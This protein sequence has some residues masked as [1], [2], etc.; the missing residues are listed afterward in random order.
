MKYKISDYKF[1]IKG[2][3]ITLSILIIISYFFSK[4]YFNES[5]EDD[6]SNLSDTIT[7][8]NSLL[9]NMKKKIKNQKDK[10]EYEIEEFD[11][12]SDSESEESDS[13]DESN[14][15]IEGLKSKK[16]AQRQEKKKVKQ[17]KK[18]VK[19][20]KKK[21]KKQQ[22]KAKKKGPVKIS[23]D[24][25]DAV[26]LMAST[27]DE[28]IDTVDNQM[29]VENFVVFDNQQVQNLE[30]NWRNEKI[31]SNLQQSNPIQGYNCGEYSDFKFGV[32][33]SQCL[34]YGKKNLKY[35]T[36]SSNPE[37]YIFPGRRVNNTGKIQYA[38]QPRMLEYEDDVN[39]E[40]LKYESMNVMPKYRGNAVRFQTG[41][42]NTF[43]LPMPDY[44]VI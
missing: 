12:E 22:K 30:Q 39:K 17:E 29:P 14:D 24:P 11:N 10:E 19:Q 27:T 40:I 2:I 44:S 1:Y 43:K 42:L 41:E 36:P 9:D 38:S 34:K 13:E 23:D 7:V 16:K 6:F 28:T 21:V 3:F 20:E 26:D 15:I 33:K 35:A 32:D 31:Q 8:A 5:F 37:D 25:L 4:Q 18:K